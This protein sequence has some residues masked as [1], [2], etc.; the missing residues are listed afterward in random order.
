MPPIWMEC[1]ASPGTNGGV[2][3]RDAAFRRCPPALLSP[4]GSLFQ[5][6]EESE[7]R[8]LVNRGTLGTHCTPPGDKSALAGSRA[9]QTSGRGYR[10]PVGVRP[11][12]HPQAQ[13]RQKPG[14][15][16]SR[17]GTAGACVGASITTNLELAVPL[18][19]DYCC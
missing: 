12:W 19:F 1:W 2:C 10:H 6:P 5:I 9:S 8:T 13:A 17:V 11:P 7:R 3:R 14:A 15:S 16:T 18:G 4:R